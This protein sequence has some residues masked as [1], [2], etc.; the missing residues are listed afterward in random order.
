MK[1]EIL[2]L[3]KQARDPVFYPALYRCKSSGVVVLATVSNKGTIVKSDKVSRD[4]GCYIESRTD[5]QSEH[6]WERL[7]NGTQLILT[8]T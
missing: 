1:V 6:N 4:V 8:Q 7:P 2:T 3:E 5:F